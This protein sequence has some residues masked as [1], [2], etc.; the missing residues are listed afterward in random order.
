MVSDGSLGRGGSAVKRTPEGEGGRKE[1]KE[2]GREE[3]ERGKE[4]PKSGILVCPMM[5]SVTSH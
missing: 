3:K 5:K 4:K 1:T 2:R